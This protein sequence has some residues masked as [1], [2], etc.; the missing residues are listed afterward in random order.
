MHAPQHKTKLKREFLQVR[1]RLSA[2]QC[3][4][5]HNA[6]TSAQNK[7]EREFLQV[8]GR[9]SAQQCEKQHNACTSAQNKTEERILAGAWQVV[10][11]AR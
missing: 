11:T 1:G 7:P 6:C 9:L 2:Q 8:R 4:K 10:C 5:Q 3:E